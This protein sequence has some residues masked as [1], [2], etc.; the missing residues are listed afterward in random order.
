MGVTNGVIIRCQTHIEGIQFILHRRWNAIRERT[1]RVLWE[2]GAGEERQGELAAQL[3]PTVEEQKEIGR[4]VQRPPA[5][6]E[7]KATE[8]CQS[9]GLLLMQ[10]RPR[11]PA[12]DAVARARRWKESRTGVT[13]GRPQQQFLFGQLRTVACKGGRSR[14]G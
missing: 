3:E 5:V 2:T 9:I 14:Q 12:G 10:V 1:L 7:Q 11:E 4:V 6:G 8:F 13:Y